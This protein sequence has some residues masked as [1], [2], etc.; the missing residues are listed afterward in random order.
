MKPFS[1]KTNEEIYLEWLNDY[2]TIQ[3]M[4]DN[5]DMKSKE[6]ET[7]IDKG[8]DEHLQK[9]ESD[10]YKK[11]WLPLRNSKGERIDILEITK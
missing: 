7:I 9:F 5:Y 11:I 4:A 2:L 10:A 3:A 6:L 1:K 8:R